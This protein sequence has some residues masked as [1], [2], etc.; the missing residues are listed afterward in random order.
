VKESI[1]IYFPSSLKEQSLIVQE[2]E[3]KFSIIDKVEEAVNNA[4]KKAEMLK[5]AILK[6]AFEGKLVME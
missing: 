3:S 6:S 2:I 4:L 5:K 1:K